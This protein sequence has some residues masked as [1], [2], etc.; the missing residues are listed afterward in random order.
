MSFPSAE[1]GCESKTSFRFV[2]EIELL[3]SGDDWPAMTLTSQKRIENEPSTSAAFSL[4]P[5]SQ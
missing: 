1:Y 5:A 4:R 2:R 3:R